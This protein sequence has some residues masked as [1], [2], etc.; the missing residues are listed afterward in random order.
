MAYGDTQH[1][2]VREYMHANFPEKLTLKT[3]CPSG[4]G[5]QEAKK[6]TCS[7]SESTCDHLSD[8]ML[9]L[10]PRVLGSLRPH[11]QTCQIRYR[12]EVAGRQGCAHNYE[13]LSS[14]REFIASIKP[15]PTSQA[16]A[17][18]RVD[19]SLTAVEAAAQAQGDFTAPSLPTESNTVLWRK[20][21][22]DS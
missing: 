19:P 20:H 6:I 7:L 10:S 17:L 22:E 21:P 18:M 4:K 9:E 11:V 3:T 15:R 13:T 16:E 2:V 8:F 12:A 1:M 5:L 14:A